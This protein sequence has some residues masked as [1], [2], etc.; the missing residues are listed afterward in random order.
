MTALVT[1]ARDVLRAI[2]E[3]LGTIQKPTYRQSIKDASLGLTAGQLN[4]TTRPLAGVFLSVDR[5][6]RKVVGPRHDTTLSIV[7]Y[8]ESESRDDAH[9]Q[10]LELVEDVKDMLHANELLKTTAAPGGL[11]LLPITHDEALHEV[12][13]EGNVATANMMLAATYRT[14]H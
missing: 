4:G 2:V 3:G 14:S 1:P 13:I 7:L 11:L 12:D 8:L 9:E 6:Q 5:D 10:M